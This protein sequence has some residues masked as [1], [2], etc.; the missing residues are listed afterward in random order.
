MP[1]IA[2]S[3]ISCTAN[4][5]YSKRFFHFYEQK[6]ELHEQRVV[7]TERLPVFKRVIAGHRRTYTHDR[8]E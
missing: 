7:V 6:R 8:K 2:D 5:P 3:Y 4:L 1:V